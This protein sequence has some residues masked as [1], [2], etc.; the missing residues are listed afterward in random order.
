MAGISKKQWK[1]KDGKTITKYVITYRDIQGKQHTTGSY[2][3]EGEA[4][5]DLSKFQDVK[6]NNA[7]NPELGELFE[8]FMKMVRRKYAKN[9][10]QAYESY[11]NKYL[12][13]LYSIKYKKLNS[14]MLQEL[15]DEWEN[16]KVYTAHNILGFCKGAINYC[17]D[18]K[19]IH[20]YNVFEE[21]DSIKRPK[22]NLHHLELED[23]LK[24]LK[25]CKKLFP[26]YYVMTFLI[27]GSGM[28]IGEVIALNVDDFT[29]NSI[30][31]NKQFT[32]DELKMNPKTAESNR[33]VHLFSVLSE[34]IKEHIRNLPEGSKLLFPNKS[35][36]YINPS[37]YRNRV[38]K[39]LLKASGINYRV[40]VHDVRGSYIDLILSSGLSDKFAQS[41]AGHEDITTTLNIYAQN[42]RRG[43]DKALDVLND[44]FI[45][46]CEQNVSKNNPRKKRGKDFKRESYD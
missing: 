22:R 38:W 19:I 14:L 7:N 30:I 3:T 1:R 2:K 35:G 42:S 13:P 11:I 46:K 6:I 31:V 45:E 37:N 41:Q 24:V 43:I 29:G 12:K 27:I 26:D 10:I 39:P 34:L 21:L 17:I 5:A 9:T 33:T 32:A 44:M 23:S 28:R 8:I 36:R 18:K 16:E 40:R 20:K 25:V 15:F 4:K